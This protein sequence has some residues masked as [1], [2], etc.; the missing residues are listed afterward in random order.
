VV[1]LLLGMTAG[2]AVF[3]LLGPGAPPGRP[4]RLARLYARMGAVTPTGPSRAGRGP[5]VRRLPVKPLVRLLR[6]AVGRGYRDK[7]QRHLRIAGLADTHTVDDILGM[8]VAAM[9]LCGMYALLMYLK[10][11]D[12]LLAAFILGLTMLGYVYPDVWLAAKARRRQEQVRRELP[13]F[14][15]A[16]AVALEAGLTLMPAIAEVTRERPGALASELRLA[17]DLYERSMPPGEALERIALQVE[18]SE[19]TVT[20]TS[21]QQAFAKGSGH[22]VATVRDQATEA[23]RKRRGQAEA[24]AQTAS[25]KLLMPIAL[26]ALPGFMIFLLGPAVLEVI[27]YV[28]K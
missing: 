18:V 11:R 20:L 15:S 22:V 4:G 6:Q 9:L 13:A 12:G 24:L 27:D 16:L 14:L 25:V 21:L 2:L 1:T 26:L 28:L 17:V 5:W 23:W 10:G 19:L 7:V 8:K 3:I